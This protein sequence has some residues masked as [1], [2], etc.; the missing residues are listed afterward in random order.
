MSRFKSETFTK[1]GYSSRAFKSRHNQ[2]M[3]FYQIILR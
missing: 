3:L 2:I 1:Y